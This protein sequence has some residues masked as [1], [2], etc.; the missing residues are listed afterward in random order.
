MKK[1]FLIPLVLFASCS[2]QATEP[3]EEPKS[4]LAP[5]IACLKVGSANEDPL[6]SNL[7]ELGFDV[8]YDGSTNNWTI[9]NQIVGSSENED[10]GFALCAER[11]LYD[12][13]M[14]ERDS[15][16]AVGGYGN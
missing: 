1:T 12:E 6:I 15:I 11:S 13:I 9:N 2:A 10:E 3:A 5:A 7:I 4:E 8:N 14:E 16:V